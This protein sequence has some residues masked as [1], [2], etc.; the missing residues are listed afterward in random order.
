MIP[1]RRKAKRPTVTPIEVFVGVMVTFLLGVRVTSLFVLVAILA[2]YIAFPLYRRSSWLI[3]GWLVYLVS[4]LLPV[5]VAFGS[6]KGHRYGSTHSGP[7]FVRCT[8]TCQP[9]HSYLL[10]TYGEYV[11]HMSADTGF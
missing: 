9:A 8:G 10:R 4:L 6:F 3:A 11:T 7:R 2:L 1:E 5:A